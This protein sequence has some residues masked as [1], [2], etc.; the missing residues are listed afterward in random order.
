MKYRIV[1]YRNQEEKMWNRILEISWATIIWLF[2]A[3]IL[4]M[5]GIADYSE[6][7][8]WRIF[9]VKMNLLDKAGI[10]KEKSD[11]WTMNNLTHGGE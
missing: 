5:M 9:E 11:F 7:V 1:N 8:S 6:S 10:K 3:V 4:L 2:G